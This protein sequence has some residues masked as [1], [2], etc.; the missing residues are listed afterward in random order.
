MLYSEQNKRFNNNFF[1]IKQFVTVNMTL[2]KGYL[3]MPKIC[4]EMLNFN[5]N[6]DANCTC[7]VY[8]CN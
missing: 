7:F 4:I 8:H 1:I 6:T 2:T 3:D 5:V